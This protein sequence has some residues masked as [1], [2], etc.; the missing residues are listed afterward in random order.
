MVA[1]TPGFTPCGALKKMLDRK[2]MPWYKNYH[3]RKTGNKNAAGVV[4]A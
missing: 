3:V 4:V 1:G 2:N